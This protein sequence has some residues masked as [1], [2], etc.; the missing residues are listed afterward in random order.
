MRKAG[1]EQW[2][3][4]IRH[5][6]NLLSDR[7]GKPRLFCL[8]LHPKALLVSLGFKLFQKVQWIK[9]SSNFIAHDDENTVTKFFSLNSE[10]R[11]ETRP[12]YGYKK[13][14]YSKCNFFLY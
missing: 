6:T 14:A 7:L 9:P 5:K 12:N 1:G 8:T 10:N 11:I 3:M 4:G 2:R 13:G